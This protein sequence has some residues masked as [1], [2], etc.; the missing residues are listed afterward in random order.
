MN[1][2]Q[3]KK[4]MCPKLV[5]LWEGPYYVAEW[6]NDVLYRMQGGPSKTPKLVHKDPLQQYRG[7]PVDTRWAAITRDNRRCPGS[8]QDNVATTGRQSSSEPAREQ[9][10]STSSGSGVLPRKTQRKM[11]RSVSSMWGFL[12]DQMRLHF[13]R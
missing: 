5:K 1:N 4:D 11:N 12:T 13:G 2:P 10:P 3:R 6:V 8:R 9:S 7:A